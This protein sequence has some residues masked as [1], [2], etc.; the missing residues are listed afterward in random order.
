MT[1]VESD[2][3]SGRSGMNHAHSS[4]RP[5]ATTK[6]DLLTDPLCTNGDTAASQMRRVI[7]ASDVKDFENDIGEW[8]PAA[9]HGP[10]SMTWSSWTAVEL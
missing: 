10:R 1:I 2:A 8:S 5:S 9:N 3:G 4:W 6:K 7:H